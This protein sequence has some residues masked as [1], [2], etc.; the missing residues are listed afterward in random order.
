MENERSVNSWSFT[1][2]T[3]VKLPLKIKENSWE[4]VIPYQR[5]WRIR[6]RRSRCLNAT[7]ILI[8]GFAAISIF[9]KH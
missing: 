8:I 9:Q 1:R 6:R 7:L 2:L 5:R 4:F 3:A